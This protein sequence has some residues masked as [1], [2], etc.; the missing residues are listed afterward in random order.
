VQVTV[1]KETNTPGGNDFIQSRAAL[2]RGSIRARPNLGEVVF[3]DSVTKHE[4]TRSCLQR[5]RRRQRPEVLNG[6]IIDRIQ[7]VG[8]RQ[9]SNAILQEPAVMISCYRDGTRI[10]EQGAG[11][12]DTPTTVGQIACAD[13]RVNVLTSE[14]IEHL[15]QPMMLRMDISDHTDSYKRSTQSTLRITN[16]GTERNVHGSQYPDAP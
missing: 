1:H 11:A 16:E 2:D 12:I 3:T 10:V 8:V 5:H 4:G 6:T 7:T 15:F 14:P 9:M 13:D